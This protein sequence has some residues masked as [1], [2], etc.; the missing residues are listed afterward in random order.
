G[1]QSLTRRG[2]VDDEDLHH[3]MV[4]HRAAPSQIPAV[5]SLLAGDRPRQLL[6]RHLRA[7]LD[8]E[9]LGALVELVLRVAFVIHTAERL[10]LA[11]ARRLAAV[12]GARVG[13]SLV[14]LG[15]PAVP[16]LLERVLHR[17]KG[18]AMGARPLAI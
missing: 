7:P 13:R 17:G 14:V 18:G 1:Q 2:I 12:P 8:V 4:A 11:L 6:L 3:V 5:A 10:S 15:D 9:I 16:L